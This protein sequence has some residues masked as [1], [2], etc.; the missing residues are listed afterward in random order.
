MENYSIWSRATLLALECKNKL[1]FIDDIIR[2]ANVG[3]DL[4]KQWDRCNALV[5]S[6]IMSNVSKDL[7]GGILFRP[8]AYSVWNDLKEKFDR[9]NLTRI[10]HLYKEVA[11]FTQGSLHWEGEGD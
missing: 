2:R 4:E 1:G 5:K 3:K 8:D 11:I 9:V 10:Y 7:L 6:W